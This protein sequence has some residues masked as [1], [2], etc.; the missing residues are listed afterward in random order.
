[1]LQLYAD[2]GRPPRPS[3]VAAETGV[4]PDR[5]KAL[6]R[7]LQLRD[8]IGLE[9]GTDAIRYAYPFTEAASGHKVELRGHLLYALCAIDALGVG[10]MYRTDITVVSPCRACGETK[11]REIEL[12]QRQITLVDASVARRG[13]ALAVLRAEQELRRPGVDLA[14]GE[15]RAYVEASRQAEALNRTLPGRQALDAGR[16]EIAL[17]ERQI[18]LIGATVAK[19][20]EELAVLRATQQLRSQGVD[21]GSSEGRQALADAR[22]VDELTRELA[23]KQALRGS[24]DE[25]TLLQRQISLTNQSASERNVV[26]AQLR[27]EQ[28][29][30]QRGIDLA[31]AEGQAIVANAGRIE[32]MTQQLQ[33]QNAAFSALESAGSSA[34]DKFGEV[35]AQGKTDWKSWADAGRAALL[36]INRE[37][38]KL[39]ITNPLKN[40][41]FGSNQPTLG[42]SGGFFGRLFGS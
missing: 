25:I 28:G 33:R 17:L 31:S 27:A 8:L 10:A 3:E 7:K 36:D 41:L 32:Q 12:L 14:S 24:Q 4:E 9:P 18:A 20:S 13:E 26:I 34:L 19:R 37:L 39:A 23:G 6:L 5:V 11:R 2:R 30:R 1:M 22:R 35:I 40:F 15:A 42:D 38:V 16:D 29:L 21:A